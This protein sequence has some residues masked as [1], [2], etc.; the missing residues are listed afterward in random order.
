MSNTKL[1]AQLAAI[2]VDIEVRH[3]PTVISVRGL[4]AEAIPVYLFNGASADVQLLNA[5]GT[6][7]EL[8][9]ALS[10]IAIAAPCKLRLAKPVT[11]GLVSIHMSDATTVY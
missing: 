9:A 3:V 8:T 1:E 6:A 2:D 11:V 4:G 5:A 7:V 10:M